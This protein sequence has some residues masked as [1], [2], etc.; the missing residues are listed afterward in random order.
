MIVI[1]IRQYKSKTARLL[2][3]CSILFWI[4]F[5]MFTASKLTWIGGGGVP[6]TKETREFSFF[7]II[8]HLPLL[9]YFGEHTGAL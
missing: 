1:S 3:P 4:T 6:L 7:E 8:L 2:A 9:F 5:Q